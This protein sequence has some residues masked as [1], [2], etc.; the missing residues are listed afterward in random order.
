MRGVPPTSSMPPSS[1]ERIESAARPIRTKRAGRGAPVV[2]ATAAA[3]SSAAVESRTAEIR[4]PRNGACSPK[5][6][7]TPRSTSWTSQPGRA[8]GRPS[9]ARSATSAV[10]SSA[11]AGERG[12]NPASS[13][14]GRAVPASPSSETTALSRP[15]NGDVRANRSAP[16]P[17][18]APPSEERKISVC[19]ASGRRRRAEP[20]VAARQLDQRG[21][22]RGVVVRAGPDAD[23]V[24]VR[25]DEDRVG[26]RARDHGHEI[27]Q[28]HA[29]EARESSRPTRPRPPRARTARASPS[30]SRPRPSRPRSP[31]ARSGKSRASSVGERRSRRCRR[32]TAAA[33]RRDTAPAGRS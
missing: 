22:S 7:G 31:A 8:G 16:K 10:R 21:R 27:P 1:E 28:A 5:P 4:R 12:S 17:P 14:R 18:K 3:A 26:R 33:P 11:G 23:V 25:E 15:R 13:S 9:W 6:N 30:P 32:T 20:A 19:W 29:A 24:P 2:S